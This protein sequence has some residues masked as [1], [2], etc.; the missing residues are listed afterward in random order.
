[1]ANRLGRNA[2]HRLAG[3]D[4]TRDTRFRGDRCAGTDLKMS[5]D[6]NLSCY[7][8]KATDFRTARYPDLSD[9]HTAGTETHVVA[10]LD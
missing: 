5:S 9:H 7:H 1:L 3:R 10:D 4:I 2:S 8:G 6:S